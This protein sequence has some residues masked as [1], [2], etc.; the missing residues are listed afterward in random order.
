MWRYCLSLITKRAVN[1]LILIN[2]AVFILTSLISNV[3][4]YSVFGVVPKYVFSKLM[5]WQF[6]TYMFIHGGLWHLLVNMLML[7]FFGTLIEGVWGKKRFLIFY[8]F[9]GIGA[10]L[11]SFFTAPNSLI[12]VVGASGAVF[13]ILVASAVMFPDTEVLFFF[14]LPMKM[15]HA[16]LVFAGINLLGALTSTGGGIAYFAHLGGGAFGYLYMRNYKIREILNF[17]NPFSGMKEKKSQRKYYKEQDFNNRV[18]KIL[19]KVSAKGLQSLSP[20]EKRILEKKS[21]SGPHPRK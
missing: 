19:D 17:S 20:E 1:I 6:F 2:V 5:L 21:K 12:P 4:W 10:G 9:T 11:C 14:F 8:F 18:D 7:W 3:N 13:G 16:V 15:R